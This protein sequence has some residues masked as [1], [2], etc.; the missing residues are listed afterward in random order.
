MASNQYHTPF[1]KA[2]EA[3]ESLPFEDRE[4]LLDVLRI[5]MAEDVREQIAANAKEA[6]SAVKEKKASYGTFEDLKKDLLGRKHS[7]I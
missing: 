3:V 6:I 1:Q 7:S 5:R 2:I 4:E